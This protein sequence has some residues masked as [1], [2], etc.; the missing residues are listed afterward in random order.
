MPTGAAHDTFTGPVNVF[1]FTGDKG[2]F[3]AA[4]YIQMFKILLDRLTKLSAEINELLRR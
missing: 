3:R 2:E 4:F 1:I